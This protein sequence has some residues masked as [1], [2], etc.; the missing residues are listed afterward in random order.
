MKNQTAVALL[1]GINVGGKNLLPMKALTDIF[2]SIG[3]TDVKTYIQSGNILFQSAQI[4]TVASAAQRQIEVQFGLKI[5]VVLRTAEEIGIA[6]AVNPFL[7]RAVGEALLHVMF[8]QHQPTPQQIASLDSNRSAPDEFIVIGKQLYLYLPN[9]AGKTRLTNAYF[10]AKLKTIGTQR[11]WRT[12]RTL[13]G[14]LQA[15]A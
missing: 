6:I 3:C 4:D 10:D 15:I 9:G 8:L 7:K 14:L 1:R 11:N 2:V 12:L 5:P 13:A